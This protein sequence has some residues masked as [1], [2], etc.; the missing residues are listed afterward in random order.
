MSKKSMMDWYASIPLAQALHSGL[1][2]YLNIK[3]ELQELVGDQDMDHQSTQV[4]NIFGS[5]CQSLWDDPTRVGVNT[6]IRS[7][8]KYMEQVLF[9]GLYFR[10]E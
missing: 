6:P 1:E 5:E 8:D 9:F 3:N 10:V 7:I 2:L 4:Y